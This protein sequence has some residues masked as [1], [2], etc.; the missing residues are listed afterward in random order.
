MNSRFLSNSGEGVNMLNIKLLPIEMKYTIYQYIDI[1]T[2]LELLRPLKQNINNVLWGT[3]R[4]FCEKHDYFIRKSIEELFI[5]KLFIKSGVN[6][7]YSYAHSNYKNNDY[8]E[9]LLPSITYNRLNR[10]TILEHPFIKVLKQEL[11]YGFYD[12]RPSSVK[13]SRHISCVSNVFEV[14]SSLKFCNVPEIEDLL[15]IQTFKFCI[16]MKNYIREPAEYIK[17]RDYERNFERDVNNQRKRFK[18][19]I[20]KKI[21]EGSNKMQKIITKKAKIIEKENAKKAKITEK[22][23]AKKR[24]L[25]IID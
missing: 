18:K 16:I 7:V 21:K 13:Y 24:K 10:T 1:D 14:V 3:S 6:N 4:E 22:E 17:K 11:L 9:S 23:N 5:N 15:K 12:Y 25:V 2:R 20:L 19:F 8:I